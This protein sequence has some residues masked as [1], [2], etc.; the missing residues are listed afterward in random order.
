VFGSGALSDGEA[1]LSEGHAPGLQFRCSQVLPRAS[2]TPQLQLK[3][4]IPKPLF[5]E[6]TENEK[7]EE[8]EADLLRMQIVGNAMQ[9]KQKERERRLRDLLTASISKKAHAYL[10]NYTEAERLEHI[11]QL[12]IVE[13]LKKDNPDALGTDSNGDFIAIQYLNCDKLFRPD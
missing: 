7:L 5:K 6:K 11:R 1:P 4:P 12:Q 3:D 8:S 9:R 10:A 13:R 2:P